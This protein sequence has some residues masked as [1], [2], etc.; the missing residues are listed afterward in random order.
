MELN[1]ILSVVSLVAI[2]G[3]A[4]VV[5]N[6]KVKS[7]N[8]SDLKDRVEI[9]E[10]ERK[11]A[12]NQHLESQKAIANLEGQLS[13]Y[14]EIPLKSIAKSLEDIG[15]SQKD[16][17]RTNSLI[18]TRLETSAIIASDSAQDTGL[19]VHTKEDSPLAVKPVKQ[20]AV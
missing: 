2:V 20:G 5:I 6:S 16:T 1:T 12:Q 11:E 7:E 19:L 10:A 4:W 9:L 17:A 8:L 13:T 14:K 18:L 15:K 3:S